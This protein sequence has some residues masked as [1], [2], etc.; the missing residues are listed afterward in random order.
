M[1][2]VVHG[3]F[4]TT[5]DIDI[6]INTTDENA[7]KILQVMLKFGYGEYD[8]E[9]TDFTESPGCIS[10]D[11]YKGKI[12]ILTSTLGVTFKECFENRIIIESHGVA[13]N[14]ISLRDLINNKK[15]VGRPKDLDDI[16]NLPSIE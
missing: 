8:F 16:L 2:V 3:Y 10:L 14:F 11:M 5:S 12:E 7:E 9:K 4:R 15:A 6:F 1:A 13:I